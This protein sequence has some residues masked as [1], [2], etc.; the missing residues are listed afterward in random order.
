MYK[1]LVNF[2]ERTGYSGT[3][4]RPGLNWVFLCDLSNFQ[5]LFDSFECQTEIFRYQFGRMTCTLLTEYFHK[6]TCLISATFNFV[7]K[8]T[9]FDAKQLFLF[10]KRFVL[11]KSYLEKVSMSKNEFPIWKM[12]EIGLFWW[13]RLNYKV[14][15]CSLLEIKRF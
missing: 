2:H 9:H 15:H 10:E 5:I 12:I 13:K 3:H 8:M 1:S 14:V 6:C 7:E 4:M 11:T